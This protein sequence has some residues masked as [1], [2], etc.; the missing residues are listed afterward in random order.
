MLTHS[1]LLLTSSHGKHAGPSLGPGHR[2]TQICPACDVPTT[3]SYCKH[4]I[5]QSAGIS[6]LRLRTPTRPS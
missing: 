5:F 4:R 6:E 2:G 1:Q 3:Q